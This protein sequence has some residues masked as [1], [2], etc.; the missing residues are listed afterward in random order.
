MTILFFIL[1]IQI[2]SHHE[3][4]IPASDQC[5]SSPDVVYHSD[6]DWFCVPSDKIF[7]QGFEND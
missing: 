7:L 6:T 3:T 5:Q 2:G 1:A 4:V